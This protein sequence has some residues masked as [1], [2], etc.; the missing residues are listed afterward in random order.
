MIDSTHLLPRL[1]VGR[2]VPALLWALLLPALL[3]ANPQVLSFTPLSGAVD[4]SRSAPLEI[5][6]DMPVVAGPGSV[7]IWGWDET[8]IE[9]IP[10]A[11]LPIAGAHVT[12]PLAAPLPFAEHCFVTFYDCFHD[13]NGN[14]YAGEDF[15]HFT[16]E[17]FEILEFQPPQFAQNVD[18]SGNLSM[19]FSRPV[20]AGPGTVE[21]RSNQDDSVFQSFAAADLSIQ[22]ALVVIDPPLPLEF[23]TGYHVAVWPDAFRDGAGSFFPGFSYIEDWMF[24]TESFQPLAFSPPD[25]AVD[26]AANA[27]LQLIFNGAVLAGPG[28]LRLRR[29]AD[30]SLVQI[31]PAAQLAIS[32]SQVT[33][34]PA[35]LLDFATG[36]YV[37]IDAGA[38]LPA[39][40]GGAYEG[41]GGPTAWNFSTIARFTELPTGIPGFTG[42]GI[43]AGDYDGDAD[44]DVLVTGANGSSIL[45]RI[46][47]NDAGLFSDIGADLLGV[48][49]AA[50]AWGDYDTDGDLDVLLTGYTNAAPNRA[51]RIYRNDDGVF[52]DI[53]AGLT[54]FM[55]SAVAWGDHDNDGDLDILICG[56]TSYDTPDTYIFRNDNGAFV[57]SNALIPGIA[58]GSV[59]WADCDHDGD[60]DILMSGSYSENQ[61]VYSITRIYRNQALQFTDNNMYALGG[62]NSCVA[63][64][65]YDNDHDL[66]FLTAGDWATRLYRTNNGLGYWMLT[67]FVDGSTDC[68]V[69]WGDF[70]GDGALD[71]LFTGRLGSTAFMRVYRNGGMA[72]SLMSDLAA[73]SQGSS[74]LGDFDGDGDLDI[75][76]TGRIGDNGS[77]LTRFFRNNS[78]H[79]NTVPLPPT[80]LNLAWS[81][82]ELAVSWNAGSDAETP[83]A[84]LSYNLDIGLLGAASQLKESSVDRTTG[85]RKLPAL[86]NA[87]EAMAWTLHLPFLAEP[88]LPQE[89]RVAVA[90]VQSIDHAW[91]GST[92]TRDT[93]VLTDQV[94]YLG[95]HNSSL[96]RPGD[97]LSWDLRQAAALAGFELQLAAN[98]GF[99]PL[100]GQTWLD[101]NT[102]AR[103]ICA[104]APLASLNGYEL[105]EANQTC[106]WRVRPVYTDAR[107]ATVFSANPGSFTL[108]ATPPAPQHLQVT[109]AGEAVQLCWEAVPGALVYYVVYRSSDAFA[110]FPAGWQAQT[111]TF[112]T[113]WT[114]PQATTAR[115]FYRVKAVLLE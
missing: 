105:L 39:A 73:L 114:D 44:L 40:G 82:S 57:L 101:V 34:Q 25:N 106:Y 100:L 72:F 12:I 47:R 63:W 83:A 75:L 10:A 60:L 28:A 64:G 78:P 38:F 65:D 92:F 30:G 107:R 19:L 36:Y 115:K 81:G 112:Q 99:T 5:V 85:W 97:R 52:T 6:F 90:G 20:S 3:R 7:V 45:S 113:S 8:I 24:N 33:F 21:I 69:A 89:T 31:V 27:S 51:T 84:G 96:M 87:S 76:Q 68:S 77:L 103:D 42:G 71:L 111:P 59:A 66:D 102:A 61:T 23:Q 48:S 95:L 14:Y 54:P 22:G 67:T 41:L 35:A 91:A 104:D 79:P 9:E 56:T 74:A 53:Q 4:V 13:G 16:V 62:L 26:V 88:P 80:A 93:L 58:L 98:P 55:D 32:G 11:D 86:G 2:R 94:E 43:S 1:N 17:T 18:V 50:A 110:P 29:S 108:V 37:E 109:V 15:W 70:D 49:G 46:Y